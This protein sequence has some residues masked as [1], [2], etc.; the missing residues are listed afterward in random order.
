M[1]EALAAKTR[2][3]QVRRVRSMTNMNRM[4]LDAEFY[5]LLFD[6]TSVTHTMQCITY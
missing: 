2:A 5:I 6:T 1:P 3:R 4:E